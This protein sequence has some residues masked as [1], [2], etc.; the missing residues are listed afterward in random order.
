MTP[1]SGNGKAPRVVRCAIY[2]RKSTSE[3]LD[4][5]FNTL[6]AQ[7]EAS[8]HYIQSQAAQ[9]WTALPAHYDD[10]GF[11]GGNLER[12]ALQRLLDDI[13]RGEVEMVVV[14]KVDRLSRSLLD[15]ARLMEKFEKKSIGFVSITQHFD[16]SSS[17]GRLVLNVLLSFAQFERE[18]ISERTRDK[19]AAAR[20]RG[21]WT[22][23]PPGLGDPIDTDRRALAVVPE[24]AEIVRLAFELYL[25]T[26]SI[27][28]VTARLNALGHTQKRHTTQV[29]KV[30]GGKPWDKDAVHRLIRN[31]L[32]VGKVKQ[33]DELYAGEQ[34]PL[35]GTEVFE[36]VQ[37]SLADRSTGR[38]VRRTRRPEY[39]L[40]GLLRCQPCDAAM[41]SSAGRGRNGKSYRYYRCCK[42]ATE[43]TACPTGLLVADEVE[44]AVVAQVREAA[45]KGD[46]QREVLA[47]L[48]EDDGSSAETQA[49][50]ERLTARLAELNG[51]AR[52]LLGAFS[53]GSAGSKLMVERLGELEADMDRVRLNLGEVE[54]RLRGADG[55]RHE[56][57]RVAEFLDGFD[58]LWDALVPAERR[59]YLRT[60]VRR[61]SVDSAMHQ[62]HVKLFD[63]EECSPGSAGDPPAEATP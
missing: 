55:V 60:L 19:I 7:R 12:P 13:E 49:Q 63:L 21:K 29:G 43:G 62:L 53:N 45:K 36:R 27:G 18:L 34:P 51:E 46:L 50:R 24:E 32:Y 30:V 26:R 40:T 54:A 3:G 33:K 23:G 37:K 22:G 52:R 9:G 6:D 31:P 8:E 14:Y 2:T 58:D 61:V 42:E 16:T 10:G 11:T 17:M 39:L 5:D 57:E 15:F 47:E 59:E 1:A 20:R 44:S 38:G 56:V 28:A 41:T 35:V 4:M 48:G 25:K